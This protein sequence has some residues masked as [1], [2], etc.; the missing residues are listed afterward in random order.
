MEMIDR[1]YGK[2]EIKES[3]L[4]DLINSNVVQRLKGISQLG[5][6]DEYYHKKGYSR[7]EHSIGV[8][9]LLRKLNA[10]LTEQI[11]G[12]LHDVSH[13]AF[14]HVVDWVLGDPTK[15]DYQ[16]NH[17]SEVFF[18]SNIPKILDKYGFDSSK[19]SN[20]ESFS[21]LERRA[22]N[23][24]VDRIDYTLRELEFLG[25]SEIVK[26]I[27]NDLTTKNGR[28][29]FQGFRVAEDF[30][31]EYM[32]L[33]NEHW[34]GNEARAR[35]YILA[36]V[37]KKGLENEIINVNDFMRTDNEV[38]QLLKETNND[39]ILNGLSLLKNSLKVLED[40]KGIELKKKFRYINPEVLIKNRIVPLTEISFDYRNFLKK[41]EKNS[42][43]YKKVN[44][45]GFY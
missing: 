21:L 38:I 43:N 42:K 33:Q 31:N 28:V 7:Y 9:I 34:A 1:V 3:V 6:P 18:N 44:I 32:N 12:L 20:I 26:R 10:D 37:L 2:E 29:V 24:C 35:Y 15:E 23:L 4:I 36:S 14:S 8:L 5:M 22:P 13:T 16:D 30:A 19:I 39:Y 40:E 25:K 17:F 41:T 11:A 27:L 45:I